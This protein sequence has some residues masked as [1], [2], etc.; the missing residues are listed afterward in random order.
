MKKKLKSV[1]KLGLTLISVLFFY[2]VLRAQDDTAESTFEYAEENQKCLKCH[3]HTY[4]NYYN[5]WLEKMIRERMNPYFIVDSA[6][7]YES[8]HRNFSCTD[9]HSYDYSS[10]PHSGELRMEPKY[11]CMDCHGG[12]ETYAKYNFEQIEEEFHNSIHSSKHSEDFT[13]WMCHNPHAYKISARTNG[14]LNETIQYDNNICLSCHA[15]IS[16]Y[17]LLTTL[18][19]PNIL[20]T[21]NWL[22]NQVLHFQSVRCIE[23]HTEISNDVLVAHNVQTKNKAVQR[24]VECHSQ[25]SI[26]KE[27]LYKYQNEGDYAFSSSK[28]NKDTPQLIG[29]NRNYALNLA[30]IIIFLLTLGGISIHVVLRIIL[31]SR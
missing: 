27:T 23:C 25:N 10:F 20:E 4:Y 3:G 9:C 18:E 15:D 13:C 12:D 2:P 29:G 5:D 1:L 21:H 14:H 31:K 7:Y 26:L 22:P 17:Q 8:N 28:D 6:K 24:C 16:K 30:S 19:N 11:T